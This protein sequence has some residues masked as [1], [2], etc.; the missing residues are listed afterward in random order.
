MLNS[1]FFIAR[2]GIHTMRMINFAIIVISVFLSINVLAAE[3][4]GFDEVCQIYTE[5]LNSNMIG[6]QLS[7]YVFSNVKSRVKVKDALDAHASVFFG[8][9]SE[10]YSLFKKGAEMSLKHSWDCP[11]MEKLM[12]L[13]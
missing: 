13:K 10:R 1:S 4:A 5:A 12:K 8:D 7:E 3:K 11:A 9:P 2:L 6:E